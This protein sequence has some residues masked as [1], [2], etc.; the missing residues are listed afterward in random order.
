MNIV[1]EALRCD[2]ILINESWGLDHGMGNHYLHSHVSV[3]S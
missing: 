1:S 2:V 3:L